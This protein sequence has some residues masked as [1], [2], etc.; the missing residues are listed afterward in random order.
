MNTSR[1]GDVSG[2]AEIATSPR[3]QDRGLVR[4]GSVPG[5]PTGA[6]SSHRLRVRAGSIA[7]GGPCVADTVIDRR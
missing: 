6:S 3:S 4:M 2:H 1:S 7:I 5:Y